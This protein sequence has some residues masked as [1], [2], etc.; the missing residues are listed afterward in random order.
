MKLVINITVI[1]LL[2]ISCAALRERTAI[3]ECKFSLVSVRPYDFTFS[4][5]KLDFEIKVDNPNSINA[6][7]DKLV[8]RFYANNTDVFSGTT[9]RTITI[10]ANKTERFTTTITL[11][12]NTIGQ[13][14]AEAMKLGSAA[15]RLSARAYINTL[16]GEVSYPVEIE[17]N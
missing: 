12:Y 11:D 10:P 16:L 3:K 17:L 15:Y 7:L 9:G 8:Y 4:N 1:L 5:L 13:A 6:V 2:C 14:L